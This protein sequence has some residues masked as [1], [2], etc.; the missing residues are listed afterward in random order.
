[1]TVNIDKLLRT[2]KTEVKAGRAANIRGEIL[3]A[4][5]QFP[6][7]A[8]LLSA[9]AEVQAAATGLPPR[10]F[11]PHH[12]QHFLAV[13]Q[14]FGL[15]PAIEEIAAATR[16][17]PAHPWPHGILGAAL[18]EAGLL[19]AA[20]IYLSK[21][22]KLDPNY[23]ES[24]VN[25]ALAQE[26]VEQ[27]SEALASVDQVLS[28]SPDFV[29]A[30]LLRAKLL[31]R[32]QREDEAVHAYDHYLTKQPED[33]EARISLAASLTNLGQS[34]KARAVLDRVLVALPQSPAALQCPAPPGQSPERCVRR[35]A[36]WRW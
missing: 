10:P 31:V 34:V 36:A 14:R 23:I 26:K 33:H 29:T 4:L 22:L 28:R 30:L 12:L 32:L 24:G 17:N 35:F 11:G 9:L 13:K 16:L 18:M 2:A 6:A 1:M 15:N 5:E 8:R 20:M 27:F 21:A 25:L 3:L 19:P 7:N